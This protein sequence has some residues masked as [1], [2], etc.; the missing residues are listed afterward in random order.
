MK[1]DLSSLGRK[2]VAEG[3]L[4]LFVARRFYIYIYLRISILNEN[5]SL[6]APFFHRLNFYYRFV[7]FKND[8]KNISAK[9]K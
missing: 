4:F 2:T 5:S 3:G 7:T 1:G 6:D 8:S 9:M